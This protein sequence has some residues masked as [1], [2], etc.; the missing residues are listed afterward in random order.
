MSWSAAGEVL[1]A[2]GSSSLST[3]T[4]DGVP[5]SP[6]TQYV[7]ILDPDHKVY[8]IFNYQVLINN[9]ALWK[10]TNSTIIHGRA[11]DSVNWQGTTGWLEWGTIDDSNLFKPILSQGCHYLMDQELDAGASVYGWTTDSATPENGNARIYGGM[12][13]VWPIWGTGA[14]AG[15]FFMMPDDEVQFVGCNYTRWGGNRFP[16]SNFRIQEA[17]FMGSNRL[18][19]SILTSNDEVGTDRVVIQNAIQGYYFSSFQTGDTNFRNV[20]IRDAP[21]E[22]NNLGNAEGSI[23]DSD[24]SIEIFRD[25]LVVSSA[26]I[27]ERTSYNITCIDPDAA[28]VESA[29]IRVVGTQRW[30]GVDGTHE[31]GVGSGDDIVPYEYTA[32]YT[33]DSG[34]IEE[35]ILRRRHWLAGHLTF[36]GSSGAYNFGGEYTNIRKYGFDFEQVAKF[37]EYGARNGL[38]DTFVLTPNTFLSSSEAQAGAISNVVINSGSN[39]ISVTGSTALEAVY[40]K[41]YWTVCQLEAMDWVANGDDWSGSVDITPLESLDG[42]LFSVVS[43]WTLEN[44]TDIVLNDKILELANG[45]RWVTVNLT[46]CPA[47]ATY[48]IKQ[49]SDDTILYAGLIPDDGTNEFSVQRLWDQSNVEVT[50]IVRLQGFLDFEQNGT[51]GSAGLNIG[52]NLVEDGNYRFFEGRTTQTHFRWR[53]DDGS[54]SAATWLQ[55]EDTIHTNYITGSAIRVRVQTEESRDKPVTGKHKIQYKK[56]GQTLWTD[57]GDV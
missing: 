22:S 14:G 27:W 10:E 7:D 44:P 49:T 34:S 26:D 21:L 46:G 55:D 38:V 18:G 43:G 13:E 24:E 57:V 42:T 17:K 20:A 1:T 41:C 25:P 35:L 56:V 30:T 52:V 39:V 33:D 8:Y 11:G 6:G 31:E 2:A 5:T 4:S 3:V 15:T 28:P 54:E 37:P 29:S 50:V 45:D 53:A 32:S 47:G 16:G 51:I 9:G 23:L 19:M 48:E 12:F 36:S 40:D